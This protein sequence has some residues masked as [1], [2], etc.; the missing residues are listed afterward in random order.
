M[1]DDLI[2]CLVCDG[3]GFLPC[4][5]GSEVQHTHCDGTGKVPAEKAEAMAGKIRANAS[6]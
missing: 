4:D 5:D 2:D 6:S 3:L 1:S